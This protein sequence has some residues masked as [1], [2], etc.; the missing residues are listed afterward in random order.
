MAL[1]R[2][3]S[4]N[5]GVSSKLTVQLFKGV[6]TNTRTDTRFLKSDLPYTKFMLV[7]YNGSPSIEFKTAS[8]WTTMTLNTEYNVSDATD[9]NYLW[10]RLSNAGSNDIYANIELYN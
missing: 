5:G 1:F 10:F 8:S 3:Q 9:T 7:S 6:G 4:G 2:C